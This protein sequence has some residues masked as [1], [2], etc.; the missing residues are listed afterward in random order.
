MAMGASTEALPYTEKRKVSNRNTE[1]ITLTFSFSI[2][3]EQF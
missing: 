2:P 3:F 1:H